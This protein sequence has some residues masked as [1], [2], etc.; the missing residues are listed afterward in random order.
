MAFPA[1]IARRPEFV[2]FE[3][4]GPVFQRS[5]YRA[6]DKRLPC[7]PIFLHH[8]VDPIDNFCLQSH[9]DLAHRQFASTS[10]EKGFAFLYYFIKTF[11]KSRQPAKSQSLIELEGD[12]CDV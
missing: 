9:F 6:S 8:M 5:R 3:W 11:A 2:V 1:V 4:A 12:F 10:E 7:L